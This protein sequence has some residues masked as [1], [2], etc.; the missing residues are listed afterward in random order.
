MMQPLRTVL[1]LVTGI[2]LMLM[3]L[4][5]AVDVGGRYFF[6]S[7]LEGAQELTEMLLATS[8]F[9]ALPLVTLDREH[10]AVSLIDHLF[11]GMADLM[12]RVVID[13]LSLLA[14][15]AFG[16]RLV[17]LGQ[18]LAEYGDRTLFLG[19]PLAPIAWFMA[20]MSFASALLVGLM[21]IELMRTGHSELHKKPGVDAL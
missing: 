15:L 16:W 8:M 17:V 13:L 6:N 12:R 3:M 19:I 18:T 7:P 2:L 20:A 1:G 5:T 11:T 21:L 9:S 14:L 10:I 4:L